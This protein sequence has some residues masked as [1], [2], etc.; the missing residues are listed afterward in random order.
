MLA[1]LRRL[2]PLAPVLRAAEDEVDPGELFGNDLFDLASKSAEVQRWFASEQQAQRQAENDHG[3][4]HHHDKN[5][6]GDDI[7]AFAL[8]FDQP[9]AWPAFGLWL[10]MLLNRHGTAILRV[11]GILAVEGELAPV[12]VHAVQQL[13]PPPLHMQRWP[14][15]NRTS[16][17]MFI[18]KG[19]DAASVRR[20]FAAFVLGST[21]GPD[22]IQRL[23][24]G[25]DAPP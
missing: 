4:H 18:C 11:K 6:H 22:V 21:A 12:A 25:T 19:V 3:H 1:R 9:I 16:R 10:S 8:S 17:I 20:S 15:S 23:V 2:N 24:G 13:V 5:R 7:E 14:G